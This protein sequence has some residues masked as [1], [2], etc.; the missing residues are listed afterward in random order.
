MITVPSFVLLWLMVVT[1]CC[2]VSAIQQNYC[3][4]MAQLQNTSSPFDSI[5]SLAGRTVKVGINLD[6][7]PAMMYLPQGSYHPNNGLLYKLEQEIAK[8]GQFK[9]EYVLVPSLSSYASTDQFLNEV[10]NSCDIYG[11][12]VVT[13]TSNRRAAGIDFS[14]GVVD[15]S[16]ILVTT[17]AIG[18]SNSIWAFAT[19][20][21]QNLWILIYMIAIFH[22]VVFYICEKTK[23][24]ESSGDDPNP[25]VLAGK[26]DNDDGPP[27]SLTFAIYDSLLMSGEPEPTT[28]ASGILKI[29]F[30][31]FLLIIIASYGANLANIYISAQVPSIPVVSI[32]DANDQAAP[33]CTLVGT[34][35]TT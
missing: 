28:G 14:V 17:T 31:I 34:D 25:P 18:R 16:I 4:E 6:A 9:L 33:I 15:N 3:Q 19:P 13:D 11:A 35:P 21:D 2:Y 27:I 5:N 30:S 24:F 23:G 32:S 26:N 8:R 10:G 1:I 7:D 12:G 22:A 29:S 20:F